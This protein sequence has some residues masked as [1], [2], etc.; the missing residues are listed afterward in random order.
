[1]LVPRPPQE[2]LLLPTSEKAEELMWVPGTLVKE[3]LL[4]AQ[5][6]EVDTF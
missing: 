6:P 2:L 5:G 1:M 3:W 4:K